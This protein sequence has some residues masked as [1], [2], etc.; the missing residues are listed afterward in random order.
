MTKYPQR[1]LIWVMLPIFKFW[2]PD[3][4][5]NVLIKVEMA[6]LTHSKDMIGRLY[7]WNG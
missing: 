2:A 3:V 6:C 5:V 4:S 7:L 1:G